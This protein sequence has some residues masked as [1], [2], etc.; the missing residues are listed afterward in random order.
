MR[1][2]TVYLAAIFYASTWMLAFTSCGG[3]GSDISDPTSLP[4]LPAGAQ[5]QCEHEGDVYICDNE[6]VCA[7]DSEYEAQP[8]GEEGKYYAVPK[9]DV[10]GPITIIAECGSN[11]VF[12]LRED[13]SQLDV[14]ASGSVGTAP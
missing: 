14:N 1:Q 13:N 8:T 5:I 7:P 4:S 3:D 2:V 9:L 10:D 6:M 12:N 11:V